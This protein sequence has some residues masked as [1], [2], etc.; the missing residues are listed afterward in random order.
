MRE[1]RILV[2]DDEVGVLKMIREVLLRADEGYEVECVQDRDAVTD[3]TCRFE[4]NLI[5]LDLN[6]GGRFDGLDVCRE[7]RASP[8][9]RSVP[10][11]IITGELMDAAES[12][13]LD[14]GADDYIRKAQ[15][16][17]KLL[18]S[19]VRA[20]LRRTSPTTR[21]VIEH[22]PL[23]LRPGR[24]E[25]L[26]AGRVVPLTPTEFSI[27]LKLADNSDRV[28]ERE[29]LLHSSDNALSRTVDVHVLSIR[30]KLKEFDWLVQ[31]V[32]G[33]GYRIGTPP[34]SG[35]VDPR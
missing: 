24:R 29:E 7:L 27:L 19:R 11:I 15:F 13:L 12:T 25:A 20:V 30:R 35:L 21:R 6:L 34:K 1:K 31:T 26:L 2:V 28:L 18:E 22:G 3:A 4:P 8:K 23:V 32:F 17:P 5:L 10:V 9:T 33:H 14:A 16:T